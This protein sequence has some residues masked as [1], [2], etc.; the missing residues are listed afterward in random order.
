M[1]KEVPLFKIHWDQRD[2]ERVNA[3]I[4]R[5][6]HWANGPEIMEFEKRIADYV[7]IEYAHAVNSGTSALH[8]LLVAHGV[9]QGDEVIVPSFTFIA[10]ANAPL[11][12]GAK[13]VF[14]EIE[15]ETYGL[16]PND[17]ER[18]ITPFTRA[19]M[20]IHYGGSPCRINELIN[21]ARKHGLI[22]IEDAAESLGA[23]A[24]SKRIGGFGDSAAFSF[25]APKVTTTGEGG[26]VLTKS[27][28]VFEK[29]KLTCNHGRAETT[30]YYSPVDSMQHIT[31]GYN[32][33]MSTMT[34]ALGL[35]QMDKLD[36][37]IRLRRD[38]ARYL[39]ARLAPID[40]VVPPAAPEDCFQVHQ[41]YTIRVKEGSDARDR[42]KQ[43]LVDN[44]I[45]AR[46]YYEP[47][48]LSRFHRRTYGY[49]GGELPVTERISGEVLTLPMYPD[50]R[51]DEMDYVAQQISG[52]FS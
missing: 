45:G 16:D 7:G 24:G 3:V 19:I 49:R 6:M 8:A 47:A 26:M 12:V 35:A 51:R 13:P 10:T 32:Y 48:H 2:I 22:L 14:A 28:D 5:G 41:M 20:P 1:K 50:I 34:A 27:R 25:C 40:Q 23:S 21:V 33:R 15:E 18:K 38:N 39:T 46:I 29:V 44:G 17:V 31:L 11:F 42:L 30:D 37:A 36:D 4:R 43:H 9:G 52:F